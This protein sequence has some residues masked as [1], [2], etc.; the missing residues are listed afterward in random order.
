MM[1]NTWVCVG[2]V[3]GVRKVIVDGFESF[4]EAEKIRS[5][6]LEVDECLYPKESRIVC[7]VLDFTLG[8]PILHHQ[9]VD[10]ITEVGCPEDRIES[11]VASLRKRIER[12]LRKGKTEKNSCA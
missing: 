1:E 9:L 12:H 10:F 2:G 8:N 7:R 3:V 6:S 4:E 5:K 11:E